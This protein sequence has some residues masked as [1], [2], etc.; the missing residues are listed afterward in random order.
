[1]HGA[2]AGAPC[3]SLHGRYVHGKK[4][5]QAIE[6]RRKMRELI[7]QARAILALMAEP[8]S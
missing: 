7:R 3:G 4:T 8:V 1:M 5:R 6:S 2:K